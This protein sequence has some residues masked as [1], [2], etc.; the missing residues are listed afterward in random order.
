MR[1]PNTDSLELSRRLASAF[2]QH[3]AIALTGCLLGLLLG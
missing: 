3:M 2:H 1:S